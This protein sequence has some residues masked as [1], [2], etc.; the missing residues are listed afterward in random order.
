MLVSL[1]DWSADGAAIAQWSHIGLQVGRSRNQSCTRGMYHE[2]IHLICPGCPQSSIVKK[3]I[4]HFISG[5]TGALNLV[6]LLLYDMP[7]NYDAD[8]TSSIL[9]IHYSYIIHL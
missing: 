4:F 1:P 2:K 8:L 5:I 9:F 3:N 7:G 6:N